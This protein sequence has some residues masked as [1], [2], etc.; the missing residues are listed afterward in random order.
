MPHA[1]EFL[2]RPNFTRAN[3]K[4]TLADTDSVYITDSEASNIIKRIT[5]ANLKAGVIP[6]LTV[7]PASPVAG[8]VVIAD[9]V[10]WDPGSG[11]GMYRRNL[12]NTL[13]V[14]VG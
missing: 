6:V 5:W 4:V 2:T 8:M 9:G 7:V 10:S 13:W 11:E 14:F 1:G 12:A 3:A